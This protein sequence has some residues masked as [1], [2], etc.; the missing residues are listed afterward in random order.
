MPVAEVG[1]MT[2]KERHREEEGRGFQVFGEPIHRIIAK[3]FA[4]IDPGEGK[5]NLAS[6]NAE[7]KRHRSEHC[8]VILLYPVRE[9]AEGAVSVGFELFFPEN[10]L[11]FDV[12][13]T[14][15]RKNERTKI[16]IENS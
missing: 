4:G 15:R 6:P 13:F 2:V 5:D 9:K 12:N 8:G 10:D 7:T 11:P 3:Y 16:V 1:E 14:V